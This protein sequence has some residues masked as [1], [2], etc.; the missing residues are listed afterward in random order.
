MSVTELANQAIA[1]LYSYIDGTTVKVGVVIDS[2]TTV[3]NQSV[4]INAVIQ[5]ALV[6]AL[7]SSLVTVATTGN[8]VLLDGDT[9]NGT[10]T[11]AK[12]SS[13]VMVIPPTDYGVL[14]VPA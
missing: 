11:W 5:N 6:Y 10:L 7:D 3:S 13:S 9:F 1:G 14:S 12:G 4:A 8:T 2:S